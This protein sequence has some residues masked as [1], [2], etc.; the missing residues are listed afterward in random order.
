[1][2]KDVGLRIRIQHELREQ[3]VEICRAQDR[4]AAQVIREFM[5][6]YVSRHRPS[7]D[8]EYQP[9]VRKSVGKGERR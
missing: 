7:N 3:F 2:K 5:R 6:S 1:M 4:P 9:Q 8:Q